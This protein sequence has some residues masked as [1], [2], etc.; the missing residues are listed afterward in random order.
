MWTSS[1][2]NAF[3]NDP[4]L[5]DIL[6][7]TYTSSRRSNYAVING[8]DRGIIPI[9][10]E[11]I[12]QGFNILMIGNDTNI[13]EQV[14]DDLIDTAKDYEV[15][16]TIEFMRVEQSDWT[17]KDVIKA[18][19]NQ[20]NDLDFPCLLINNYRFYDKSFTVMS[21]GPLGISAIGSPSLM[22]YQSMMKT[23]PCSLITEIV[24][25]SFYSMQKARGIDFNDKTDASKYQALDSLVLQKTNSGKKRAM[26]KLALLNIKESIDI[27]DKIMEKSA[28]EQK[29][30]ERHHEFWR[31]DDNE[32]EEKEEENNDDQESEKEYWQVIE[33]YN[34]HEPKLWDCYQ[35]F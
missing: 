12:Q 26:K 24:G 16:L 20:I 9:A 8:V 30:L 17:K 23:Y 13:L 2:S 11:L 5:K 25:K 15:N 21:S 33:Q 31:T 32:K 3:D 22:L 34:V 7:A 27:S 6:A 18:I 10:E 19:E 28:S 1:V 14:K 4:T 35:L 29:F